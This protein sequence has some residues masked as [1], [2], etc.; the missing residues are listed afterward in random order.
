MLALASLALACPSAD[1][2]SRP[3]SN[4]CYAKNGHASQANCNAQ[5]ATLHAD[6]TLVCIED[7]RKGAKKINVA[8]LMPWEAGV[9]V[10]D[11]E[12]NGKTGNS[13]RDNA[14]CSFIFDAR[15]AT[16][17]VWREILGEDLKQIA[18][19]L[20]EGGFAHAWRVH[21]DE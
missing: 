14:F 20:R 5:C 2:L 16:G 1:W 18:T 9:Y 3:G 10:I 11:P 19:R 6:A 15:P 8:C 21:K 7:H 13:W 17:E 4:S 12:F